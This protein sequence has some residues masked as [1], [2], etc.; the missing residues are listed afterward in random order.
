MDSQL[1]DQLH[2]AG[3]PQYIFN[4]MEGNMQ[5]SGSRFCLKLFNIFIN[6]FR[7]GTEGE[8]IFGNTR[9]GEIVNALENSL[10]IQKNLDRLE[11]RL[12]N[13][14]QFSAAKIKI[15]HL[16]KKIQMYRY[17]IGDSI[18]SDCERDLCD[19]VDNPLSS[20]RHLLKSHSTKMWRHER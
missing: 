16:G 1:V 14:M 3:N 15:I 17:K 2:P 8:L 10:N 13:K 18:I 5:Q 6:N 20:V 12:S 11:Q 7:K 9:L 19:L 4:Y